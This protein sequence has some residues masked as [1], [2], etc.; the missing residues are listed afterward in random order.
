MGEDRRWFKNVKILNPPN[1]LSDHRMIVA[2]RHSAIQGEHKAYLRGTR[3]MSPLLKDM[4]LDQWRKWRMLI[5]LM[6]HCEAATKLP[7]YQHQINLIGCWIEQTWTLLKKKA[8][9]KKSAD[10]ETIA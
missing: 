4:T 5:D 9:L 7:N 8:A 2:T 3:E 1:N 6:Q 10:T